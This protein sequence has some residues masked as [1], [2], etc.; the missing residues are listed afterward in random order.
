[1]SQD[2]E[3]I[4]YGLGDSASDMSEKDVD[5]Y[6]NELVYWRPISKGV[7]LTTDL[8]NAKGYSDIVLEVNVMGDYV[9][10]SEYHIFAKE[11]KDC[12]IESVFYMNK[13][14]TIEEF[15]NII[16]FYQNPPNP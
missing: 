15:L 7:N 8:W 9:K 2:W 4:E 12:L 3:V 1:M 13:Q 16:N 6:V 11:P 14:Y 5:D 10:F